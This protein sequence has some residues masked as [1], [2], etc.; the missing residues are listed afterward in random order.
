[1]SR[2]VRTALRSARTVEAR[3]DWLKSDAERA[4]FL[5]WLKKH[6][7]ASATFLATCRRKE[8][9][10]RFTGDIARQLYWLTQARDAGCEWC[11]IEMETFCELPE[12]FLRVF[13]PCAKAANSPMRRLRRRRGPARFLSRKCLSSTARTCL[14]EG[15]GFMA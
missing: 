3:L 11:D 8:G 5:C 4:Q 10:G 15:R 7:S 13:W 1:M 2:Q 14:R 6:K 12:G 9:G